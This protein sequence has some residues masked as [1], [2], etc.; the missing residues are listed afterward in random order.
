MTFTAPI[1]FTEAIDK[2]RKREVLPSSFDSYLWSKVA[3]GIRERAFFS[4]RVENARVLGSMRDYLEEYLSGSRY[5]PTSHASGALVSQGRSEFVAEM[6]ELA[7]REGLGKVDPLTGEIAPEIDENDITDL[8]SISRLQLIFDTQAEAAQEFGYWQQGQDPDV[9]D[10]FP[11]QRF[12]RVRPVAVPRPLHAA[13][14]GVVR[15]KDDLD[16]WK[17]MNEDFGVPWGPWGFNSG[18]GVEDVDRE[19]AEALGVIKKNEVVRPVEK[20]LNE[21]LQAGVEG[22]DAGLL[23]ALRQATGGTVAGGRLRPRRAPAV[24]L[25]DAGAMLAQVAAAESTRAAHAL[26]EISTPERGELPLAGALAPEIRR[27]AL[28]GKAFLESMVSRELL[29]TGPVA[30]KEDKRANGRGRYL[31]A[32]R[33]AEVR[34]STGNTIHELAHAIEYDHPEVYRKCL[35]FRDSRTR[36]ESL[37]K[38]ADLTGD[39]RYKADELAFEDD[40]MK[41]GGSAYAGKEYG[42]QT[43]AT[44]ILTTGLERLHADPRGFA[45][46][47]PDYF[48]F[49]LQTIRNP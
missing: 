34:R 38:L 36:G 14:E 13:N 8:R 44:E 25:S 5:A 7:I 1:P 27:H 3:V 19:E 12:I 11:A 17:R 43:P 31:A 35:E 15:R 39:S 49:I 16:F 42:R 22:M 26:L 24:D 29:P 20:E 30:V 47:D 46:Q 28:R 2:L 37:K 33:T 32:T 45:A 48:N 41:R 40:W 10:V 4:A 21:G 9:L 23:A 6:R 18:M